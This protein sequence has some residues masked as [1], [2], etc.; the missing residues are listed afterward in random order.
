MLPTIISYYTP[1][2]LYST[3]ADKMRIRCMGLDLD[4]HIVEIEGTDDWLSNT[5]LKPQFILDTLLE[6]KKPVLWIDADGSL[7]KQPSLLDDYP[8][9]IGLRLRPEHQQRQWHVG[10]VFVNYTDEAI[11]FM[12]LWADRTNNGNW[13]DEL[14]LDE[15]WNEQPVEVCNLSIGE[16]P[17]EYFQMLRATDPVPHNNTVIAHRASKSDNKMKFKERNR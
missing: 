1:D 10:T 14:V 6:L 16:L 8:Y 4:H 5:R 12:E 17:P 11:A 2:W 9:D 15:L 13:S 3:Y 7:Y